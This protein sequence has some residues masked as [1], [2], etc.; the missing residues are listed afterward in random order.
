MTS[1]A[2]VTSPGMPKLIGRG[3]LRALA[4]A[5]LTQVDQLAAMSRRE[6]EALNG[7]T[8]KALARLREALAARGKT[9]ADER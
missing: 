8:P 4:R 3:P 6:L 5:G 2:A 7:M 9:F 1:T